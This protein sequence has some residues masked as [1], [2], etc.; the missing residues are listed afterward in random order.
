M[1][2]FGK[3]EQAKIK[4]LQAEID[5]LNAELSGKDDSLQIFLNKLHKEMLETIAQHD[6]VNA[7]HDV[8]GQM[9]GVLLAEFDKVQDS[10]TKSQAVSNQVLDQGNELTSSFAQM[11]ENAKEGMQSVQA[12]QSAIDSLAHQLESTLVSMEALNTSSAQIA[13]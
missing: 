11:V 4:E 5:K 9:V 2:N 1:F 13:S 8:L 3:G 7:Q 12:V 6:I 10:T